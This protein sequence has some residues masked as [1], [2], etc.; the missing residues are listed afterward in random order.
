[1]NPSTLLATVPSDCENGYAPPTPACNGAEHK[2]YRHEYLI[3]AGRHSTLVPVDT[4]DDLAAS[5][6]PFDPA[7]VVYLAVMI[8]FTGIILRLRRRAMGHGKPVP[9][10]R[11]NPDYTY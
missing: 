9:P 8:L 11:F 10:A 6:M 4:H 5:G 2:D 1:M 7:P 3:P